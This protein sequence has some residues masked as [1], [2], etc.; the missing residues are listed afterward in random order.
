MYRLPL[1]EKI[2]DLADKDFVTLDEDTL[3]GVAAK[4]MRDKD[5]SCVLVTRKDSNSNDPIGIVTER[6]MLYRVLAENKGR[7]KVNLGRIMSSPLITIRANSSAADAISIMRNKNIRR[8]A[9]Q[10]MKGG[11]ITGIATL[12]S[13][14]GNIPSQS[15]ELAEVQ[16]P[17]DL[18]AVGRGIISCP[19]CNC[20]FESKND[21]TRH[22]DE[23]HILNS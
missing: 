18:I 15:I 17:N 8:L 23:S 6:D 12:M 22:I 4:T 2:G 21:I 5:V 3:V 7:F 13:V 9:V 20:T 10:K 19:Y 11:K 1:S 14:V 16:L